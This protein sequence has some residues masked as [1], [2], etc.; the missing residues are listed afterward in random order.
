MFLGPVPWPDGAGSWGRRGANAL[1]RCGAN[2]VG[3]QLG[4]PGKS[5]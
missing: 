3:R 5:L 4:M 1:G 2:D